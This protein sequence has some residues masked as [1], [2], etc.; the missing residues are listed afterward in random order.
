MNLK[1]KIVFFNFMI[2][3]IIFDIIYLF[4]WILSIHM[5]PAKAV[6]AAGIAAVFTPWAR[7]SNLQSGRKVVIRSYAYLL[8]NKYLKK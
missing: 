2:F 4:V 6:I 8:Y 7:P 5:N 1:F 3:L